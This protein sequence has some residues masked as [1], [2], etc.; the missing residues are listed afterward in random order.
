MADAMRSLVDDL[1]AIYSRAGR[2]VT[3]KTERGE[4]R[5]YWANRYMQALKRAVEDEANGDT[6]AVLQFVERLVSQPEPSRG[7]A[8]LLDAGRLDLSVEAHVIDEAKPYHR[9][10]SRGAIDVSRA[11]LA[12]YGYDVKPSDYRGPDLPPLARLHY[13]VVADVTRSS[14]DRLSSMLSLQL[15]LD[16]FKQALALDA[17]N[18]GVS[19]HEIASRLGVTEEVATSRFGIRLPNGQIA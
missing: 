2:E 17:R 4:T 12:E 10:F 16:G 18:H 9:L 13:D 11:R 8:Y 5:P 6:N 19:W 15:N 14:A 7:F 3:Y 1:F